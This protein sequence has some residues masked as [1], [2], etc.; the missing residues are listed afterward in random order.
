MSLPLSYYLVVSAL[1]L[2]LGLIGVLVRRN[3]IVVLLSIELM[4]NSAN[5]A[6]IAAAK[7]RGDLHGQVFGFFIIAVVVAEAAVGLAIVVNIYRH[8]RDANIDAIKT[9]RG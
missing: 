3:A 9:M 1:L 7:Y 2:G 5:L 8:F 6:F 4:L